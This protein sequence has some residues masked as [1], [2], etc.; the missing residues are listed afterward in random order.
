MSNGNTTTVQVGPGLAGSLT[1][2]FVILKVT[3]Y[4]NWSWVWVFAPLWIAGGIFVAVMVAILLFILLAA[5]F[6]K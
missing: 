4:I 1:I 6:G 5:I 3:G 2:L